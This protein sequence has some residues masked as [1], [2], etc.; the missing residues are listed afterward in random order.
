[1]ARRNNAINSGLPANF[2]IVNPDVKNGGAW[3]YHNQGWNAY[4]AMQ[5]EVRRRMSK[6][7]M[8]NA[9]YVFGKSM[10]TDRLSFLRPLDKSMG[11]TLPH[12]FKATWLYEL[13]VGSGR[14]L[15]STL[16]RYL[17][18][19][20]GGWEFQGTSRIQVGNWLSFSN[21]QLV[22]MTDEDLKNMVGLRFDDVNKRIY[23][24]PQDII[25]QSYKA[26]Q[27]DTS[28]TTFIQ[29]APSGRFVAPA[30]SI[31]YTLG[32]TSAKCVQVVSRDCAQ[33]NHY[34]QGPGFMRFDLSL[35]K[36]VRFTESKNFE[37]RAE[38][39]NAFNNVNFYGVSSI[40]G[41]SSGQVT[42]AFT[43]SSQQQDNGGRMIQIVM[44]F[45]F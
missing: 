12:V 26:Y 25:D 20:V 16:N 37:V 6:G 4:D 5:V 14:T 15:G 2:F 11:G 39:L 17:D 29:G 45:N 9:S 1:M 28:L 41:L 44:R 18:R 35:V 34:Y 38:F 27:Y 30:Q 42:S 7:L 19:I 36:R 10:G 32:A 40:G 33:A 22:G 21:V 8:L 24:Y 43:D 13:P 31:G 3:L 23:Y